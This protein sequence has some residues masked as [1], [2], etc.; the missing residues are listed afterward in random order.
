MMI[1]MK[2]EGRSRFNKMFVNGSK[3]EYETKKMDR[4]ALYA[5]SD[6]WF[7]SL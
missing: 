7:K 4:D 2:I 6:M 5:P 3:R 1:G